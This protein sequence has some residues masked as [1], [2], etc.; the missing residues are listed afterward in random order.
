MTLVTLALESLAGWRGLGE[1]I[2]KGVLGAAAQPVSG[3][4]H[5]AQQFASRTCHTLHPLSA[6]QIET[7]RNKISIAFHS[8]DGSDD[9][10][11]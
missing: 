3:L 1:G 10:I 2:F 11:V 8:S 6:L 9:E 5:G 7:V 4:M